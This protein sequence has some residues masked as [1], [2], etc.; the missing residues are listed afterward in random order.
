M[1]CSTT[2]ISSWR[3][4]RL[5]ERRGADWVLYK[6]DQGLDH[7]LID[8]AQDTNPDQW[9][10]VARLADELF[11]GEGAREVGRTLFA[12]GD[13]KQSIFS[14]QRADPAAFDG[15]REHFAAKAREAQQRWRALALDMSFR[16]TPAILSAIDAVF[17]RPEAADGV[18]ASGE[19]LHHRA[20]RAGQAGVVELWPP[21]RP[22]E[23][24]ATAPWTPPL[25]REPA[26]SPPARL[27]ALI[28]RRIKGWIDGGK[29]LASEDRPI[30]AGDVMVL[31]RRRDIFV[32]E[33]IR[34]LK[35]AS[36]PV[37]G[38]DRM[39]LTDQLAVM[40]VLALARF[41]LL[42]EDDLS[43]AC[44][45]KSPLVGLSEE[46]LLLL[47]HGRGGT[48]WRALG[49]RAAGDPALA[50]ARDYLAGL[51]RRVDFTPPFE[52]LAAILGSDG[53]PEQPS[54][55]RRLVARLG[56]DAEEPLDELLQLALDYERG[57]SPS[58]QGFV[59][60]L[61]SGQ[62]EIKRDPEASARDEVRVMTVH[63]AK[64]L[65]APIVILPDTM[66]PPTQSPHLLWLDEGEGGLLW[67][68]R[69]AH[70]GA[71]AQTLRAL[72]EHKR[73]Q[74][75]R[76]LLYVAM[77]RAAD[78]LYVCGWEGRR[79]PP[80]GCWYDLVRAGLAG[81]AEPFAFDCRGEIADGWAGE[82]LRHLS[83]QT[84][85][86]ERRRRGI[87]EESKP[88]PLPGWALRPPPPEPKPARPL[89]PSRPEA[90]EP[91]IYS[92]L[93][94]DQGARFRRGLMIHR[95]LEALPELPTRARKAACRRFLAR[96]A[97]ALPKALQA[98]LM[99]ETLAVLGA[100]EFAPLFAPGSR[101]EVPLTGLV[102]D[103][104]VAG[105]V[106]RLVVTE[107]EVLI[108]DYKT[109]RPP[110]DSA[111]A[112]AP[113]YL[114]QMAAYRALLEKIYPGKKVRCLLLWTDGPRLMALPAALLD[115][116]RAKI[117]A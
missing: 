107:E 28:A 31:V 78:R 9:Q 53:A 61:E 36:V 58:L 55:R 11:A 57:H 21:V 74:E 39:V 71:L 20:S 59:H 52:L 106:D 8:E 3:R 69:R 117:T 91:A 62:A 97:F 65:E 30:H 84:T 10:V 35:A 38:I 80:A 34:A 1:L 51:L 93:G 33:L 23:R 12:V 95:L 14:F 79:G 88:E 105:Q 40:D 115:N 16:S 99:A 68:P 81:L 116:Y 32:E 76:R 66:Q 26:D 2:T 29:R 114:G 56:P 25:R 17:A 46:Q 27:A 86:P 48:L 47:C 43:L 111:A 94:P 103:R 60:W 90:E 50:A 72:A 37:A 102:G 104:I 67:P 108:V 6:L 77:T 101:A 13:A 113:L 24:P 109:N 4:K 73:D 63:G 100:P 44:V 15:M 7:I 45:L 75:Y 83:P 70:E 18:A 112:V 92:P 22:R 87:S 89:A 82:G 110:P 42:P 5:L 19:R 98:E 54:G 85:A 64:G 49:Q 96:A 41:L